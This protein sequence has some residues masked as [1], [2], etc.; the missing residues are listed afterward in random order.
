MYCNQAAHHVMAEL[1][2]KRTSALP[3]DVCVFCSSLV[4][5]RTTLQVYSPRERILVEESIVEVDQKT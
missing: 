3:L 5:S 1:G 2:E 4:N